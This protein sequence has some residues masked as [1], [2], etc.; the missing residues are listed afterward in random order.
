MMTDI[1]IEDVFRLNDEHEIYEFCEAYAIKNPDFAEALVKHFL[2]GK[3]NTVKSKPMNLNEE[4]AKCFK[5][6]ASHRG[7]RDWGPELDWDAI[8]NDLY[9][10]IEKGKYMLN[11]GLVHEAID[12]SLG[13]LRNV[14]EEYG[15]DQ[16]YNDQSFDGN[17][18]CIDDAMTLL[19]EAMADESIT[20]KDKL[21]ISERLKEISELEAYEDYCLCD[22]GDL[23]HYIKRSL[24]S[25]K[26]YVEYLKTEMGKAEYYE[27][28][29]YAV[30]L[31]DYQLENR[32]KAEAE[33]WAKTNLQYEGM[34][35]R[36]VEWL[37]LEHRQDDALIT[38]DKGIKIH[39][40]SYGCVSDWEKKKLEIYE[41]RHDSTNIIE[42][43][44]KLFMKERDCIPYYHK[45]KKIIH[46]ID[47]TTFLTELIRHKNFDADAC[48]D[49]SQIYFEEKLYTE[50]FYTLNKTNSNLL[51]AL[52]KY[53]KCL[54]EDQQ[55]ILISKIE[56]VLISFAEHQMGRNYYKDLTNRLKTLK[57]CCA[58]GKASAERLV[59]Q[60]RISY[61]NRPAMLDELSYF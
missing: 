26:D 41:S 16:V 57:R 30:K 10:M 42:Q 24:L 45:L 1:E 13:I 46:P 28:D 29:S 22:F 33:K 54:T 19:K 49:L 3:N 27:K 11:N 18:F 12:L 23:I 56:L 20:C 61:R 21:D 4:I 43:C 40:Y 38:L 35:D 34:I 50:L 7:Y 2:P 58:V 6:M 44:R 52:E 25:E 48:G 37:I 60:F 14:G 47:W 8:Q 5:H 51:S 59:S 55:T 39:K 31:F 17:D 9:R 32:H 36:Y 53:A 15:L